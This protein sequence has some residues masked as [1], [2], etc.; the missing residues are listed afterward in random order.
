MVCFASNLWEK[1]IPWSIP[2]SYLRDTL[3]E[4]GIFEINIYL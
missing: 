3:D 4:K 1:H 2:L